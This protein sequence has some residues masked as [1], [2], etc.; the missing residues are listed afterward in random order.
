MLDCA[1]PG[2]SPEP[3]YWS[4]AST[5]KRSAYGV[6]RE[7]PQSECPGEE[8]EEVDRHSLHGCRWSKWKSGTGPDSLGRDC[9]RNQGRQPQRC[10]WLRAFTGHLCGPPT[11]LEGDRWNVPV[12]FGRTRRG[13]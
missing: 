9:E 3:C 13:Q 11:R 8:D 4:L 12:C 1:P 10:Q 7:N 2:I 6:T 5:G